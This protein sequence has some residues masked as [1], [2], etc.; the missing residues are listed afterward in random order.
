MPHHAML[1]PTLAHVVGDEPHDGHWWTA[2]NIDPVIIPVLLLLSTLYTVGLINMWRRA[3]T[4]HG[5]SR[6]QATAFAFAILSLVVALIS[7][8]D[9]LAIELS[10][11]HMIQHMIIMMIAAPLFVIAAPTRVML[12]AFTTVGRVRLGAMFRMPGPYL[13]WQPLLTWALY[14]FTLWIW[15]IPT[16][17]EAALR[18]ELVHDAQH[19]AFFIASCLFWR[20]LLDPLSRLRLNLGLGVLYL[21]TSSLHSSALGVFLALSPRVWYPHYE[22]TTAAWNLTALEDQQLA[23]LVMWMPACTLYAA[24]AA[25]MFYFWMRQL[26]HP[27]PAV[28]PIPNQKLETGN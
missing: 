18:N 27:L 1:M 3:G 24:A 11:V 6:L 13:L 15:H 7:P 19:L 23:G 14:A 26:Q 2:W 22:T 16:L 12:F 25:L 21:F 4:G 10:W 28:A 20:V 8:V 17:Y 9:V 5:V